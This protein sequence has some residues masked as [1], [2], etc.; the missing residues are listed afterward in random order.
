LVRY[1]N[2]DYGIK[3]F[4]TFLIL[5]RVFKF[6]I[7]FYNLNFEVGYGEIV[8][9]SN[10]GKLVGSLCAIAG[11]LTIALPVPIVV[12]HF[13]FFYASNEV[14]KKLNKETLRLSFRRDSEVFR[15]SLDKNTTN[16][17]A[18]QSVK[19]KK[20]STPNFLSKCFKSKNTDSDS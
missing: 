3:F 9:K 18:N 20:D 14:V 4:T 8:P 12:S 16:T 17:L 1:Y 2:N 15:E 13:Q 6:L 11:V 7:S 19:Q 5:K 10:I